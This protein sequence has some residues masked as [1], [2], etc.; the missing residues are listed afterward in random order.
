[1]SECGAAAVATTGAVGSYP[2]E[3]LRLRVARPG[4]RCNT[5]RMAESTVAAKEAAVLAGATNARRSPYMVT[6]LVVGVFAW[7]VAFILWN[8]L[9]QVTDYTTYD[10]ETA[11]A[12]AT[13]INILLFS[14]VAAIVGAVA[15]AGIARELRAH[16][17]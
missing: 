16:L 4:R 13:W 2:S 1:M 3:D 11:S 10:S 14:G 12:L 15:I 17:R 9:V 6:L 8:V 7:V 5:S